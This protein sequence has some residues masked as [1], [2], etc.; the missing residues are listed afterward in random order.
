M[1]IFRIRYSIRHLGAGTGTA[2]LRTAISNSPLSKRHAQRREASLV[3]S[4][5]TRMSSGPITA[6]HFHSAAVSWS[7]AA[8]ERPTADNSALKVCMLISAGTPALDQVDRFG[9]V[10]GG[11]DVDRLP[12]HSRHREADRVR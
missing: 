9:E 7:A 10:S 6:D 12:P 2:D 4:S 5:P 3:T 1:G 11:Q 8:M